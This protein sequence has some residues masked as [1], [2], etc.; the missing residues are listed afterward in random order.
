MV[1]KE[2]ILKKK[3]YSS[4]GEETVN[5]IKGYTKDI[6]LNRMNEECAYLINSLDYQTA[7]QPSGPDQKVIVK[8]GSRIVFYIEEYD[9]DDTD[10]PWN[11]CVNRDLTDKLTNSKTQMQEAIDEAFGKEE[12]QKTD[13][14]Q[15]ESSGDA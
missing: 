10:A 2:Y 7:Q 12:E 15:R 8:T 13:G 4:Y 9:V 3:E 1:Y 6:L 14:E 11:K 5:I